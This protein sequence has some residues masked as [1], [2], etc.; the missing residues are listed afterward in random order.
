MISALLFVR[1]TNYY[2]DSLPSN[3]EIPAIIIETVKGKKIILKKVKTIT[4]RRIKYLV[5]RFLI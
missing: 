1:Q 4:L 5:S 2:V 3:K